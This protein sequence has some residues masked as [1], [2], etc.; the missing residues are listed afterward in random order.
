M[1]VKWEAVHIQETKQDPEDEWMKWHLCPRCEALETDQ[2]EADVIEATFKK[3]MEHKK[4]RVAGTITS[5]YICLARTR[6]DPG[7]SSPGRNR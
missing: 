1:V 4:I 6:W 7:H 3:P 5:Y 2:S